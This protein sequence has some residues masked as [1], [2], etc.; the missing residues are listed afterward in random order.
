MGTKKQDDDA[1][2]YRSAASRVTKA[3]VRS[4][5]EAIR[6]EGGGGNKDNWDTSTRA[7][8]DQQQTFEDKLASKLAD[9]VLRANAG[10]VR[11]VHSRSSIKKLLEREAKK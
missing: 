8:R 11:G 7:D 1:I 9:D 3:S 6:E 5:L 4:R 2:S 10:G